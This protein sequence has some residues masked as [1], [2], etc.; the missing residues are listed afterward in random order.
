MVSDGQGMDKS[1]EQ[2]Q[3]ML[4]LRDQ[5]PVAAHFEER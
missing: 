5:G 2:F 4:G 3:V 1:F